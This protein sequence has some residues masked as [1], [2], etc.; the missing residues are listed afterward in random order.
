MYVLA[1]RRGYW[2]RVSGHTTVN[3][4]IRALET[5]HHGWKD[6]SVRVSNAFDAY[7]SGLAFDGQTYPLSPAEQPDRPLVNGKP[8]RVLIGRRTPLLPVSS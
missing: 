2:R 5:R 3:L 7:D 1:S 4:P 6:L 8:G